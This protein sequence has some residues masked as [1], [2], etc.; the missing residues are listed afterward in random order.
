MLLEHNVAVRDLLLDSLEKMKYEDFT[1]NM[2]VGKGSIHDILIHLMM[3]EA[4]WISVVSD[5]E[6]TAFT[7]DQFSDIVSIRKKWQEIDET[8]RKCVGYQSENSLQHV[9]SVVWGNRT[10]SFT[11]GRALIHMTTHETHHRGLIVGLMRQLDYE[12]PSVDML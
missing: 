10:V 4:Y 1:R 6:F 2:N 5:T 9:K 7:K 12:P 3:A 11:V 8:T